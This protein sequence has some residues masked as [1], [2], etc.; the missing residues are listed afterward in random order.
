MIKLIPDTPDGMLEF[1]VTGKVTDAD[2][3]TVLTPEIERALETH[4]RIR[5]LVQFGPGFE[6]YTFSAAWDDTKLGL[7]HWSGFERCAVVS[8]VDWVKMVVKGVSFAMPCPIRCFDLDAHDDA[9]RWLFESLGTI[10]VDDEGDGVVHVKLIGKLEPG[11]YDNATG[12]LDALIAK[13]GHIRL[14]LD[15]REFDGWQGLGALTSH[16]SLVREHRRAPTRVAI[17]GD[18]AWMDL[19]RRVFSVFTDAET[20]FFAG[21]GFDDPEA[22]VRA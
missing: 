14:L 7:R 3:E 9:R 22:W 1:K 19:A 10:H 5:V 20:R 18:E 13:Y 16:L 15:L 17:V 21:D 4:D 2:Y 8:D 6:G 12:D 11:A